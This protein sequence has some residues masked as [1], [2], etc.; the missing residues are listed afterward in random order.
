M[1]DV[2]MSSLRANYLAFV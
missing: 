1:M 2:Y